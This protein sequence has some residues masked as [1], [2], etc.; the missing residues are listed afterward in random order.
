MDYAGG[1]SPVHVR[2]TPLFEASWSYDEFHRLMP[3]GPDGEGQALAQSTTGRISGEALSGTFQMMQYP[4][5]R[6]DGALLPDVHSLVTTD[7][8][9]HVIVRAGGLGLQISGRLGDRAVFH[10]ARFWTE[11]PRLSLL[12]TTLAFGAGEFVDADGEA[13]L[14]YFAASPATDRCEPPAGAPALELLGT[15][16]WEYPLYE[17]VRPFGD[18]EGIGFAV[19]TGSVVDG[20][21]AGSWRGW[22]YPS[23][24][25]DGLYQIDAH[26]E[27]HGE[28]GTILNRH[29]GLATRP[30]QPEE[31]LLYEIVQYATFATE[32]PELAFIN[33][34]LALGAGFV[35]APG[36]VT[37]S[38]YGLSAPQ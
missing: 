29:G 36:V 9:E 5:W 3:F 16:R 24:R 14:R 21:L 2:L 38:Y 28:A 26:V 1:L 27:I 12:N 6:V 15:A 4:R 8:G 10:W 22:H 20:P 18:T 17:S 33:D 37:L 19:S 34:M 30:A 25:R 31:G 35:H 7:A 23:Y 13:R 32:L 11:A